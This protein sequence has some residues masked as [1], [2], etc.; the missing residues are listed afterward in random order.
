M[1]KACEPIFI[2]PCKH[3]KKKSNS[4]FY[5]CILL[6]AYWKTIKHIGLHHLR[7]DGSTVCSLTTSYEEAT[8]T[9]QTQYTG[10]NKANLAVPGRGPLNIAFMQTHNISI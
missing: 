9:V 8:S 10:S 3:F 7:S 2:K 5:T 6:G 4:T 1:K